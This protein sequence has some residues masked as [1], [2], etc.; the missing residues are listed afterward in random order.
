MNIG[1][2]GFGHLGQS[3]VN[4]LLLN[5]FISRNN[6]FVTAKSNETK[7]KAIN[8]YSINI[9]NTNIELIEKTDI[10]FISIP[11]K[12]F[13]FE[14]ANLKIDSCENKFFVSLMAGVTIDKL[15]EILGKTNIIRA[16]PNLGIEKCNGIICYTNTEDTYLTSLFNHLGFAFAVEETDIEKVTAFASCGIGFA[17]YVLDCFFEAGKKMGFSRDISAK[18]VFNIFSNAVTSADY[19]SL[20]SAVATKGGATEAGLNS[21]AEDR[22]ND[23]I[24][25]AVEKAYIKIQ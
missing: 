13:F 2:I 18:I 4:G 7:N 19:S 10:I 15:K 8:D 1:V 25:N 24:Y 14:L 6:I 20:V 22:L 3:L 9:C 12:V 5:N 17:A 23:I 16:M 21:F 11:S